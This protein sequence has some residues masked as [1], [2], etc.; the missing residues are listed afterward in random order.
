MENDGLCPNCSTQLSTEDETCYECDKPAIQ[1]DKIL[2]C[3]QCFEIVSEESEDE[4]ED[5]D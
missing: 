1:E 4:D 5:A 2:Y 3:K